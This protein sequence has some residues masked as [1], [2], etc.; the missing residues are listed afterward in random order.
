MPAM[1]LKLVLCQ[2][3][4]I[5]KQNKPLNSSVAKNILFLFRKHLAWAALTKSYTTQT[6]ATKVI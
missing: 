4:K 3:G 2:M 6:Q 5:Y 1:E